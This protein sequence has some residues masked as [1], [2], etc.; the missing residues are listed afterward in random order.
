MKSIEGLK[1]IRLEFRKLSIEDISLWSAFF[2]DPNS[3]LYIGAKID[4]NAREAS[5]KWIDKQIGRYDEDG[6]GLYAFIDRETNLFI[7]QC[8]L[9]PRNIDGQEEIE[10]AYHVLSEFRGMGYG[11]EAAIAVK[12]FANEN[13]IKDSLISIIHVDNIA[14]QKVAMKNGMK[15]GAMTRFIEL[16][17]YI[18][19]VHL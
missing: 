7:G 9:L 18:Y 5:K 10:I 17:V 16:D 13:K 12:E 11:S 8:G 15:R 1:S 3:L 19:R 2:E 14:S 4:S 6:S